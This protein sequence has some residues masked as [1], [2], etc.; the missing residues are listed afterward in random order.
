MCL[1]RHGARLRLG[2]PK[3]V[4]QDPRCRRKTAALTLY[5]QVEKLPCVFQAVLGKTYQLLEKD[6]RLEPLPLYCRVGEASVPGSQAGG[7]GLG[8]WG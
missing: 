6:C 3:Q 7:H 1:Y 2:T 8:S 4:G 5:C